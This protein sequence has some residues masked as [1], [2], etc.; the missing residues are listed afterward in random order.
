MVCLKRLKGCRHTKLND[1]TTD[2]DLLRVRPL[3][4][5]DV[6]L[7]RVLDRE[8]EGGEGVLDGGADVRL[9]DLR[10]AA[11]PYRLVLADARE[12]GA[13]RVIHCLVHGASFRQVS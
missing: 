4:V 3:D 13:G 9:A 7:D 6:G 1:F 11:R 12:A 2:H 5:P 8:S 10:E